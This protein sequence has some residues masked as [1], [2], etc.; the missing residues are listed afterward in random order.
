MCIFGLRRQD[1]TCKTVERLEKREEEGVNSEIERVEMQFFSGLIIM[2][3]ILT[4]ATAFP[5]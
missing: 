5:L 3:K 4:L 2:S 1:R